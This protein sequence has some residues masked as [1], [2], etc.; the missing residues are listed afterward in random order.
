MERTMR[1]PSD[2]RR[3]A[4]IA[5]V[6]AIAIVAVLVGKSTFFAA[7]AQMAVSAIRNIPSASNRMFRPLS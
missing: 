4:A 7:N 1:E 5:G 2:V 6:S 3:V